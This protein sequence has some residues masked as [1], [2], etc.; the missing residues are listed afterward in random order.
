MSTKF[1]QQIEALLAE[2]S[3]DA[4]FRSPDGQAF[5]TLPYL[6]QTFPIQD[7]I[8]RDWLADR[9]SLREGTPPLEAA[10]RQ[11]LNTLR[12]RAYCQS[13]GPKVCLRVARPSRPTSSS[14]IFIDLANPLSEAVE[15]NQHGWQITRF[16]PG[17][18]FRSTRGQ[19]PLPQPQPSNSETPEFSTSLPGILTSSAVRDWLLAALRPSGPYP[20]LI[21]HGPPSSGKTTLARMLRSLIDPVTAPITALPSRQ[22]AIEKLAC[23][24]RVL[25]FD[26]VT[27]MSNSAADALCRIASGTGIEVREA[28]DHRD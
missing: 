28:G 2:F 26:H 23:R 9:Y 7:P 15:I 5:V 10:L 13:V 21:L 16:T 11:A 19:L 12:A 1:S 3:P 20:I 22:R 8:V 18:T 17:V 27:H 14:P 4:V 24:H 25:A 6:S